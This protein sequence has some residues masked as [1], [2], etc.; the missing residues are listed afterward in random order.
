MENGKWK[1]EN[2]KESRVDPGAFPFTIYHLPF[3]A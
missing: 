1:M 3:S 2:G